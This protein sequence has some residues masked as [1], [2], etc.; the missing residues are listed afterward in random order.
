MCL[1]A[2]LGCTYLHQH[3]L[4][5]SYLLCIS[6]AVVKDRCGPGSFVANCLFFCIKPR[7]LLLSGAGAVLGS[8]LCLQRPAAARDLKEAQQEKEARRSALRCVAQPPPLRLKH[9]ARS[10]AQ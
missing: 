8:M 2:A 7:T 4:T 5:N 10:A 3:L 1:I 6:E 9:P